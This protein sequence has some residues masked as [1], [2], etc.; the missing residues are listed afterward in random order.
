MTND[1]VVL[2]PPA[3]GVATLRL[4]RP[5][6]LN[7]LLP[8]M[9]IDVC[10]AIDELRA[11]MSVRSVVLRGEGRAFCAGDDLGPEDRFAYGP[12]DLQTRLKTGYPRILMELMNLRKPVVAMIQGYACGA[13]M[14][15]ALACDFRVAEHDAKMAA[16]FVKRGLG[17]GCSYLLPRYVGFGRATEFLLLGDWI[18]MAEAEQ[19]G[20]V[21]SV[22]SADDLETTTYELA[23]RLAKGPTQSLGSIKIARNQGLGADP[24]KGLEYQILANVELMFYRDAREGRWAFSEGREPEFTNE[25]IDLQYDPPVDGER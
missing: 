7:A 12:P 22:V 9:I 25:W 20:L 1:A 24:V 5:E 14:D 3:D 15:V 16:I 4:N 17:G 19:L 23:A 13:G 10:D 11:D 21:T 6:K 2:E 8:S 18:D